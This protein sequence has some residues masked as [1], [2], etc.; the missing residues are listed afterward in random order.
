MGMIEELKEKMEF[1]DKVKTCDSCKW[2]NEFECSMVDRMW[3]DYCT[4]NRAQ[5]IKLAR[6]KESSCKYHE[7]ET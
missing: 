7:L 3:G 2:C 1:I 6:K 5:S 4:L